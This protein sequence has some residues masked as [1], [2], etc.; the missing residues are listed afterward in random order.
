MLE[1]REL[2]TADLQARGLQLR[3]DLAAGRV[4]AT[5]R[6]ERLQPGAGMPEI[7]GLGMRCA[8]PALDEPRFGCDAA[9]VRI[10]ASPLG[11]LELPLRFA[12][13][14]RSGALEATARRVAFAG[15]R[16]DLDARS[17]ERDWSLRARLDG[18]TLAALRPWIERVAKLPAG[19][20]LDGRVGATL[21]ASGHD[22]GDRG[23]IVLQAGGIDFGNEDGT[24]AGEKVG[25]DAALDFH[26]VPGGRELAAKLSSTGGQ[27]LGGPVLLDF[28]A[29]PLLAE[30]RGRWH[31]GQLDVTHLE[32]AQ[33]GLLAASGQARLEL[34]PRLHLATGTLEIARIELP[35]AYSSF[36]QIALAATDF[37]TLTTR[38]RASA[39]LE[40]ADDALAGLDARLEGIDLLDTRGK[41]TMKQLRGE[42]HWRPAQGAAAPPSHLEW[43]EGSA[44]GLSGGAAALEFLAQG[45]GVA[46]TRP[47]RLPIFDGALAIRSL[48][49]REAG[50]PQLA[51]DFEGDIEPISMPKLAHAFGWSEFAG[52]LAGRIPRVEFRERML[53]VSGDLVARVFDGTITG[54][55]LRLQDPLGPWP[56]LFADVRLQNLDLGLV[57]DTFTI[58]SITGRLEGEVKGLEL[59]NWSPVAFDAYLQTPPGYRGPR[60][61]SAKA[62]GS[63]SNVGGG[64]G[65]V[66]QALQSGVFRMFDQYDYGQLGIRCRLANEVCL[67]SGVARTGRDGYYILQGRGLPR[68]NIIGNAGRVNW[69]QLISQVEAQMSGAGQMRIE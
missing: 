61:I 40:L 27:A 47:A 51:I 6:V 53:T 31:G 56:R 66:V 1:V 39:R 60:R 58:G 55:R 10:G 23:R 16:L 21:E 48:A 67:M 28:N 49:V 50:T 26:S 24:I 69:P 8:A 30:G 5:A 37:G 33:R 4:T 12:L 59:F 64:G 9:R 63:L 18:A 7:G 35:A 22:A 11:A 38:G 44:Y 36:L 43:S 54:S 29:N 62:V 13:D 57:T 15:G 46:L 14:S 2:R 68:V 52:Q 3:L 41:F 42:L 34:A 65:G 17:G 32:F 25:F 20:T 19:F 45:R